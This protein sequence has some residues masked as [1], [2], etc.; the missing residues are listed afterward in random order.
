MLGF[1][2]P[3]RFQVPD[4]PVAKEAEVGDLFLKYTVV[5]FMCYCLS[6]VCLHLQDNERQWIWFLH[7]LHEDLRCTSWSN[8]VQ[9]SWVQV[10]LSLSKDLFDSSY[11]FVV[12][13]KIIFYYVKRYTVTNDF[14]IDFKHSPKEEQKQV[15]TSYTN[16]LWK[17]SVTCFGRPA[18]GI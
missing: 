13:S 9:F 12:T 17:R 3:N 8:C 4:N 6:S 2:F 11:L 14:N 16:V 18:Y 15:K 7:H 10:S 1:M 5:C